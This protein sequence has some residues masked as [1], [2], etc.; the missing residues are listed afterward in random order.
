MR[1]SP[2]CF[3]LI[4]E[5][6][7]C[8]LDAYQDQAGVWTVG[9]GQTGPGIVEGTHVSQGVAEAMLKDTL[10]HLGDDLFALVGWRL[11]QNQYDALISLTYNIGLGALKNSTMLKDILAYRLPDAANEFLKWNHVSGIVNE[12]LTNRRQA[13]KTLFLST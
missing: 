6:E 12:G 8:R 5:Y 2:K 13:E 1:P 4:K 7:G 10:S 11:N 3:A 9:Y